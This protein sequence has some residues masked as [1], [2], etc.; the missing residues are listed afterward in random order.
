MNTVSVLIAVLLIAAIV[1]AIRSAGKHK[2]GCGG[3]DGCAGCT[4]S[5]EKRKR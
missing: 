4:R 1:G 3:C 2:G 5:C